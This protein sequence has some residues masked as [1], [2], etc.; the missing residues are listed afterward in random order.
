MNFSDVSDLRIHFPR[1]SLP[2]SMVAHADK[3]SC[4]AFD[5]WF[6]GIRNWRIIF[7]I[8]FVMVPVSAIPGFKQFRLFFPDQAQK[9]RHIIIGPFVKENIDSSQL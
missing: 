8:E 6:P 1:S 7:N 3:P 5:V 4:L 2:N 9:C